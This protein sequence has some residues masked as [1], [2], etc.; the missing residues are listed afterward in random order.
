MLEAADAQPR[1]AS[2][3]VSIG[4]GIRPPRNPDIRGAYKT[5]IGYQ[6]APFDA[7]ANWSHVPAPAQSARYLFSWLS[8]NQDRQRGVLHAA[9]SLACASVEASQYRRALQVWPP[10]I[11]K[12]P[13]LPGSSA[14][15]WRI[16]ECLSQPLGNVETLFDLRQLSD[17]VTFRVANDSVPPEHTADFNEHC[18]AERAGPLYPVGGRAVLLRRRPGGY[19]FPGCGL[20]AGMQGA[21]LAAALAMHLRE[22]PQSLQASE[23]NA[24][25]ARACRKLVPSGC[26]SATSAHVRLL[27]RLL[28]SSRQDPL[29][30]TVG[31]VENGKAS[32][33]DV[34]HAIASS[35]WG[36]RQLS[37]PVG[38]IEGLE[39]KRTALGRL[40][41]Q[42]LRSDQ[43]EMNGTQPDVELPLGSACP[44]SFGNIMHMI[45]N[46][47]LMAVVLGARVTIPAVQEKASKGERGTADERKKAQ[48]HCDGSMQC[49]ACQGL[50]DFKA[51]SWV[52]RQPVAPEPTRLRLQACEA[53]RKLATD[54]GSGA[55][56]GVSHSFSSTAHTQNVAACLADGG[57]GNAAAATLF[58]LGP[59]AAYGA[60]YASLFGLPNEVLVADDEDELRVSLHLRHFEGRF[61]GAEGLGAVEEA[62]VNAIKGAKRC[63]LL[64]A[65]DRMLTL[66]LLRDVATRVRCRLLLSPRDPNEKLRNHGLLLE[67]GVE[68]FGVVPRD[69]FLLSQGDVLIGTWGS[70]LTLLIQE[71]LATRTR[72]R[73]P[74]TVVYCELAVSVCMQ[75]LPL[76]TTP[77]TAWHVNIDSHANV[78]LRRINGGPSGRSRGPDAARSVNVTTG[79]GATV[80]LRRSKGGPGG[81]GGA[82]WGRSQGTSSDATRSGEV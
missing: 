40:L 73:V 18:P 46:A 49:K 50:L 62:V 4:C 21:Q 67:H 24:M 27:G 61:S 16:G 68:T 23:L 11:C 14:F 17:L 81:A 69:V 6:S 48:L 19:P 65:S 42:R 66:H 57:S 74:P 47:A 9:A 39:G 25:V 44:R 75:P 82:R 2:G 55:A 8:W 41:H 45:T 38:P 53:V 35:F 26:A 36:Q 34:T 56:A 7:H 1:K 37:L 64:A 5:R 12:Q 30:P 20:F 59:H 43:P 28:L 60:L 54:A 32:F 78:R 58:A 3:L 72:A 29:Q 31:W 71:L 22:K 33:G 76:H 13:R 77:D 10:E 79:N 15:R 70:T 63:A 80:T 51:R 52:R